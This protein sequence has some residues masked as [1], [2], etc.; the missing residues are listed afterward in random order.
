MG[1]LVLSFV[2]SIIAIWFSE[3]RH[4]YLGFMF[5]LIQVSFYANHSYFPMPDFRLQAMALFA[6]VLALFLLCKA[7]NQRR[8]ARHVILLCCLALSATARNFVRICW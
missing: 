1:P 2:C 7:A 8:S 5:L 4:R 3:K 6:Q